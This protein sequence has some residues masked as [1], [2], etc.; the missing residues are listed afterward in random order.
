MRSVAVASLVHLAIA[1]FL[2]NELGK[3]LL[4]PVAPIAPIA[5][6]EIVERVADRVALLHVGRL[7]FCEPVETLLARQFSAAA[8][9]FSRCAPSRPRGVEASPPNGR[10]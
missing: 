9:Q 10:S 8:A 3:A 6:S 4:T 2:L 7:A 5:S 1:L